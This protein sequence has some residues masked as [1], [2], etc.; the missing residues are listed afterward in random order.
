MVVADWSAAASADPAVLGPDGVH[1]TDAGATAYTAV[2]VDGLTRA[3]AL[4]S[5][6]R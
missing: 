2:V 5:A 6:T 3:A 4:G 1:P